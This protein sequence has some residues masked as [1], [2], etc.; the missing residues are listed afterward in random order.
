MEKGK[1]EF[2]DPAFRGVRKPYMFDVNV[3]VS[4]LPKAKPKTEILGE[5]LVKRKDKCDH[6]GYE[7]ITIPIQTNTLARA[8]QDGVCSNC[9]GKGYT[10]KVVPLVDALK[11]L[12]GLE[13]HE[14]PTE[15]GQTK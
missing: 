2:D 5:Y 6:V 3:R 10:F 4:G 7:R 11:E 1:V 12:L 13:Y 9:R 15:V 14:I 8:F